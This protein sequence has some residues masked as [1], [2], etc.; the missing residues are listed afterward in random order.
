MTIQSVEELPDTSEEQDR[1]VNDLINE[2]AWAR[3]RVTEVEGAYR[4]L[5]QMHLRMPIGSNGAVEV[6]R[7]NRRVGI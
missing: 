4:E 3:A 1:A 5:R 2:L 7:L 6:D